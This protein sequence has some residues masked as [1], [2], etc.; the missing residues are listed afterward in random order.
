MDWLT[1]ATELAESKAGKQP[2][3]KRTSDWPLSDPRVLAPQPP[4]KPTRLS[5][6]IGKKRVADW[7]GN[8]QVDAGHPEKQP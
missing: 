7:I 2:A 6:S 1:D 8:W 3:A 5:A 4:A